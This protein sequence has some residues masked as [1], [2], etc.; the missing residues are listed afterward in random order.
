MRKK[1][2]KENHIKPGLFQKDDITPINTEL[3]QLHFYA[4]LMDRKA[5]FSLQILNGIK[6][7]SPL[8]LLHLPRHVFG[9][10]LHHLLAPLSIPCWR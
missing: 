2:C 4:C 7:A 3:S 5:S 6:A 9:P 1:L 10:W 8:L